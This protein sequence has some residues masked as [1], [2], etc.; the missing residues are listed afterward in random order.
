MTKADIKRLV[1]NYD[2]ECWE[3]SLSSKSTLKFYR[4]GKSKIGYDLCYRNNTNSMF[5]ARARMNS[6]K[7]EEAIGRGNKNYNKS[8]KLCHQE[9]EDLV[10]FIMKCPKLE[11]KRNYELMNKEIEDPEERMIELLF[12]QKRY[13]ETGYM[14]RMMWYERNKILKLSEKNKNKT[15]KV[16]RKNTKRRA[17]TQP[18]C[19]KR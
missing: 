17:N 4:E 6:L 1:R 18:A 8:C 10:H 3:N 19:V 15:K 7:L 2:N 11:E 5:L 14:L 16:T 12:K 9:E 13:Q